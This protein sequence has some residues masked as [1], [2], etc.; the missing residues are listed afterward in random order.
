MSV[1][2][3][4]AANGKCVTNM[5]NK[6]KKGKKEIKLILDINSNVKINL[7]PKCIHLQYNYKYK[8]K[9]HVVHRCCFYTT[10]DQLALELLTPSSSFLACN[11]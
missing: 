7:K 8:Y 3:Q 10:N 2:L 6:N 11:S 5:V 1:L 4:F 9:F